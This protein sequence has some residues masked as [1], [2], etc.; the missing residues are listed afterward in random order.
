LDGSPGYDSCARYHHN[1]LALRTSSVE[2]WQRDYDVPYSY[3]LQTL[4]IRIKN[5]TRL[6]T[7][8]VKLREHDGMFIQVGTCNIGKF[9]E[10]IQAHLIISNIA[11]GAQVLTII[12]IVI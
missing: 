4:I 1:V 6:S 9:H 3:I 12:L 8:L 11:L 2:L 5:S 7:D 10:A